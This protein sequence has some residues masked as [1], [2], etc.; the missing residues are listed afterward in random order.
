MPLSKDDLCEVIKITVDAEFQRGYQH[1][2]GAGAK[3]GEQTGYTLAIELIQALTQGPDAD[4]I[5]EKLENLK[6]RRK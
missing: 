3:S 2:F 1:G 5:V 4:F 6:R